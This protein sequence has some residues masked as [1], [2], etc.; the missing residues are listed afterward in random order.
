MTWRPAAKPHDGMRSGSSVCRRSILASRVLPRGSDP[1][2]ALGKHIGQRRQV[3]LAGGA[4]LPVLIDHL[5]EGAEADGDQERNDQG[6]H[7]AAKRRLRNQQPMVGRFRDRLRQSLDRIGLDARV[8]RMRTR[9][10]LDPHRN[11]FYTRS[12]EPHVA[13]ESQRFESSFCGL[14]R[15]NNSL[16]QINLVPREIG[17]IARSESETRTR[18]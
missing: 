17:E 5:N 15:V 12:K 6:R 18:R 13:S 14:S 16:K 10:A 8:R 2:D 7:G 9:H 11:L 4:L 1:V 3:A